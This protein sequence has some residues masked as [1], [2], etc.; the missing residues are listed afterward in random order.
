MTIT[1]SG[2]PTAGGTYT[3]ECSVSG[4]SDPAMNFQWSLG[5][6]GN[7]TLLTSG[8]SITINS[9]SSI[10][11]L[12]FTSLQASHGRHYTCQATVGCVAVEGTTS[13]EVDR[14]LVC[15]ISLVH[16]AKCH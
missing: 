16:C 4:T 1:P 14:K 3:L 10:S 2:S 8:T 5:P 13:V 15:V 6:A 12:Q 9:N 7:R 11:Q